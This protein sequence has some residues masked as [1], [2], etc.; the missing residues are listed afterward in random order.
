[1]VRN[2]TLKTIH[3]NLHGQKSY[4]FALYFF[5]CI[6]TIL[7]WI[8]YYQYININNNNNIITVNEIVDVYNNTNGR[9]IQCNALLDTGN[10]AYTM[11]NYDIIETIGLQFKINYKK[12]I[13]IC[14][15]NNQLNSNTKYPTV[16]LDYV[17]KGHRFSEKVIVCKNA[18][19]FKKYDIILSRKNI[20]SL[21]RNGFFFKV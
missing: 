12:N 1:M 13:I 17:I 10:E 18:E 8:G 21:T 5:K 3:K 4:N 15:V 2:H 16:V 6:K 14:G 7:I 9:Q 11:I 20:S 19:V